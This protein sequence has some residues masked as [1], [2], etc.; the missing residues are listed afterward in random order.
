MRTARRVI[1]RRRRVLPAHSRLAVPR[2]VAALRRS[3]DALVDVEGQLGALLL[4]LNGSRIDANAPDR[5]AG[6]T[7]RAGLA[8]AALD[9]LRKL[10]P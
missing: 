5:L 9:E 3:R 4:D 1:T 6:A 10:L 7:A 2:A 8:L